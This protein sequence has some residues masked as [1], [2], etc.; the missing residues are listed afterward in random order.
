MATKEPKKRRWPAIRPKKEMQ[1]MRLK[2]TDL[3]TIPNFFTAAESKAFV[4][5]AEAVGFIHQGSLGPARGEAYRDNDRIAIDDPSLAASM[6]DSGLNT[7]FAD[8]KIRGKVA[9]G[10]N[11]NIRF[12]RYKVGQHFGQH[13][14]ESIDLGQGHKTYY[15][16]LVYLTGKSNDGSVS[17]GNSSGQSLVG[18]ETV[19]YGKRGVLAEVAPVVG[20]ALVH[21]HGDKCL[22]H[23][24]RAVKKDVK[25]PTCGYQKLK[26]G[27]LTFSILTK[28][29]P[30][31]GEC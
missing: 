14:D 16:L 18:G 12:Y 11:P 15:T 30:G 19:F 26:N 7:V 1:I 21:L 10:L 4:D 29:S 23:E 13:I 5:A 3:F 2:D 31:L 27:Q 28:G 25:F 9:V 6:W 17:R 22:L 8:I 20:M 24:A